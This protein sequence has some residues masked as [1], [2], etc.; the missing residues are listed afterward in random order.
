MSDNNAVSEPE[1]NIAVEG[2][3]DMEESA[4]A[5]LDNELQQRVEGK[6]Q[7]KDEGAEGVADTELEAGQ[8]QLSSVAKVQQVPKQQEKV[9]KI[10]KKA[11]SEKRLEPNLYELSNQLEK[12]T[13]QLSRIEAIVQPLPK[14]LKN[15][16]TQSKMVK[17]LYTS[18]K[19]VQRQLGQIQKSILR[20]K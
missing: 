11:K 17:E 20:K 8:E 7:E 10:K 13:K 2:R 4:E 6:V 19:Q 3:R 15:A 9:K 1:A 16:D 12:H 14:H 18:I 5:T